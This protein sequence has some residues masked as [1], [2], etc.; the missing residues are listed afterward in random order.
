MSEAPLV[1][2]FLCRLPIRVG[3]QINE[4][5][6]ISQWSMTVCNACYHANR[7]GIIPRIYPQVVAHL[8]A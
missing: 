7:R 4:I 6:R 1:Y 8:E 2:C 3:P 5:R